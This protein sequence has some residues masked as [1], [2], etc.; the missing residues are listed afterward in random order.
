MKRFLILSFLSIFFQL[1]IHAQVTAPD[2][3]VKDLTGKSYH[4]Y[5]ILDEG[6]VVVLDVSAT[7]C[8]ICWS[9]HKK[10]YLQMIHE[11]YGP[12]GTN[13]VVVL[14]YEGDANTDDEALY[15]NT[16]STQGNWIEGSTYPFINES[17]LTINMGVYSKGFPTV[18]VIRPSD[19]KII[20]D[21]TNHQSNGITG[22]YDIIDGALNVVNVKNV[23][24]E[25]I[26]I[27][28][29][30]VQDFVQVDLS[31]VSQVISEIQIIDFEGK[32]LY[33]YSVQ[34]N[35]NLVQIP[36]ANFIPGMYI[37]QLKNEDSILGVKR[38]YKE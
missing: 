21:L 27:F 28:P 37:L 4:L 11:K 33:N 5:E 18:N 25:N 17:P 29:N 7:W 8:S 3:T 26:V 38:F 14:F 9:F 13:Q 15:G 31:Q 12:D 30:P 19:K 32:S 23:E 24:T 16:G 1:S 22:M 35:Q 10:H 34:S 20:A 6:K 2:F 36:V